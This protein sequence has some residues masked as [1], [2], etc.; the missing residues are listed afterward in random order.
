LPKDGRRRLLL[1]TGG[2]GIMR[3]NKLS[4]ATGI[5]LVTGACSVLEQNLFSPLPEAYQAGDGG[6]GASGGSGDGGSG[7]GSSADDLPCDVVAVLAEHCD[8]CHAVSTPPLLRSHADFTAPAPSDPS[9]SLAEVS[10]E[11]MQDAASPM[12]PSGLPPAADVQVF[13][14]WVAAGVP[15]G[16]CGGIGG[17]GGSPYDVPPMCSSGQTWNNGDNDGAQMYPGR[18][19]N[20]CHAVEK[21]DQIFTFAGTVYPTAHEPDDCLG[22]GAG[23]A[24]VE[25]TD[26]NDVVVTATTNSSGNFTETGAFAFPVTVRGVANGMTLAMATPLQPEDGDRNTCHDQDG[27]NGAPGRIILPF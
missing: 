17:A 21:P 3:R 26:A 4:W 13:A 18:A 9:K 15:A 11:R 16:D 5:V 22:V 7:A 20:E 27:N 10:L 14:A 6:A 25:L 19:C 24:V 8:S 2:A 12:P 1:A 23:D